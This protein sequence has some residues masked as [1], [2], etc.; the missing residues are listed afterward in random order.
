MLVG[1]GGALPDRSAVSTADVGGIGVRV[2]ALKRV[3]LLE[4]AAESAQAV[5]DIS[6]ELA[7]RA[8]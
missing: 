6:G 3:L 7:P 8:S 5:D 1:R 2:A 4:R